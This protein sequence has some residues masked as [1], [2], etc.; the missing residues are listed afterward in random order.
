MK[1][2]KVECA[3]SGKTYGIA[4]NIS[5]VLEQ[6]PLD[7][8]IIAITY[9]NN[10]VKEIRK[11]LIKHL[12]NIPNNVILLTIDTFFLHYVIYPFSKF[13]LSKNYL[14]CSISKLPTDYRFANSL[15]K[16]MLEEKII[17]ASDVIAKTKNILVPMKTDKK[18]I[19]ERKKYIKDLL[20]SSVFGLYIDEIQDF[21]NDGFTILNYLLTVD[22]NIYCVGDF[23]QAIKHPDSFKNFLKNAKNVS[24]KSNVISRRV[25]NLHLELSNI[26]FEP[27]YK[28][29]NFENKKGILTYSFF[30]SDSI[31]KYLTY[32]D[33]SYIKQKNDIFVTSNYNYDLNYFTSKEKEIIA[34]NFNGDKEVFFNSFLN[35]VIDLAVISGDIHSSVNRLLKKYKISLS[36]KGTFF[37]LYNLSITKEKKELKLVNSIESVKGLEAEKCLFIVNNSL[38]E[39]LLGNNNNNRE[40]NLLYVALTRSKN[41]LHL[42]FLNECLSKV[43]KEKILK[44]TEKF[45]IKKFDL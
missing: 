44:F 23:R 33:L 28:C 9:T 3:G 37:K 42:L 19:I 24:V 1:L 31:D 20:F 36:D 30:N 11:E 10:A 38:L 14:N 32:F 45:N 13:I 21:D 26:L 22:I 29:T 43:D 18:N 25:P 7:K 17:H 40:T 41:H 5:E 16:R 4:Y 15:K 12:G 34:Q 8:K 39:I 2:I 6:C 27:K 35:E